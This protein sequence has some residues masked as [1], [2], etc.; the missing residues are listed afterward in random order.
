MVSQVKYSEKDLFKKAQL[1]K[2]PITIINHPL[3][4]DGLAQIRDENTPTAEFSA[5]IQMLSYQLIFAASS[6]LAEQIRKLNTPLAP[7]NASVIKSRVVLVPVL[8]SGDGM[9][10]P[11]RHIFPHAPVIYAGVKRDEATAIPHWYRDLDNLKGLEGGENVVFFILDPMLA[12]GGSAIEVCKRIKQIYPVST[13]KMV[14][15]IA[16]PEGVIA[17]NQSYPNVTISAA[18]LDDHL[19]EKSYIVP[20]LGD[21]GDRQFGTS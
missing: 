20:G 11:A 6:D 1:S 15:I 21:A 7:F 5:A 8:R 4:R 3:I 12:T 17:L 2:L 9:L 19:N 14:C 18:A 16:A 10:T 13:I